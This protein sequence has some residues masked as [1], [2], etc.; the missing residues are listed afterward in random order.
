MCK[1]ITGNQRVA[2]V[3][4]VVETRRDRNPLGR[5]FHILPEVHYV[6]RRVE[7]LSIYDRVIVD[8]AIV[9]FKRERRFSFRDRSRNI[10]A[11]S[12]LLGRRPIYGKRI[13]GV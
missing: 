9:C 10:S 8:V 2:G 6:K 7:Y 13:A 3:D 11:K 12:L 4:G 1:A 5:L